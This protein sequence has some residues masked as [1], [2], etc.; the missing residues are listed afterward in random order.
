M[1]PPRTAGSRAPA[2]T[3]AGL[4]FAV[5]FPPFSLLLY[6]HV[7]IKFVH[8]GACILKSGWSF[9][10]PGVQ[11]KGGPPGTPVTPLSGPTRLLLR[12]TLILTDGRVCQTQS[13]SIYIIL[14]GFGIWPA[15]QKH[16]VT[17]DQGCSVGYGARLI[18]ANSLPQPTVSSSEG[19]AGLSTPSRSLAAGQV[20]TPS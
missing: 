8:S 5:T 2:H 6:F 1:L 15:L 13:S 4:W 10:P 12:V 9:P 19:T 20:A 3:A 14:C 16:Q 11:T 7:F 17:H 18:T